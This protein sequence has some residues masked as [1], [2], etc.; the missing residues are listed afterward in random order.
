MI[1]L[2]GE[3]LSSVSGDRTDPLS[4]GTAL[5]DASGLA[6]VFA[7]DELHVEAIQTSATSLS[8]SGQFSVIWLGP[9]APA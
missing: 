1:V 2:T 6:E 7:G 5:S 8:V 4:D 9:I 3:N